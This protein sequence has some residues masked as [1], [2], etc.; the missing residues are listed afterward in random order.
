MKVHTSVEF[1]KKEIEAIDT[2]RNIDCNH[3]H[4]DK[5]PLNRKKEAGSCI[6]TELN[7]LKHNLVGGNKWFS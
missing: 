4:C 2:L 6:R 3:I 1:S 7:V 5:C